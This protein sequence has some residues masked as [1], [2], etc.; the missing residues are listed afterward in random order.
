MQT[1]FIDESESEKTLRMCGFV[2]TV[3]RWA[4][5]STDWDIELNRPPAIPSL[6]TN[7]LLAK[8]GEGVFGD[9]PVPERFKKIGRLI[10][11]INRH[12]EMDFTARMN[13]LE[14]E[15]TLS[16]ALKFSNKLAKYNYPYL[17]LFVIGVLVGFS[18]VEVF[19]HGGRKS[20][21]IFDKHGLFK[22]ARSQY[23]RVEQLI[24]PEF[25]VALAVVEK[26][27]DED[28]TEFLPLQAA[29]LLA[30]HMN[31]SETGDLRLAAN[32]DRLRS[33]GRETHEW[34]VNEDAL[35][36]AAQGL[37]TRI[38]LGPRRREI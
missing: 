33:V 14:Y 25:D 1:V 6:H 27:D 29:D 19:M 11:L 16:Q 36:K 7:D 26:V 20:H 22:R 21:F 13:L 34:A 30:W 15:R 10:D 4:D 28:D 17:W 2:S 32:I 31:R 24:A 18:T 12:T 38:I 9:I 3:E 35:R 37:T 5:F 8:D 23:E